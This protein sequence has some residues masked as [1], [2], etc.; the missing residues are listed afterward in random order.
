MT[1]QTSHNNRELCRVQ[2]DI[3]SFFKNSPLNGVDINLNRDSAS[4]REVDLL[5]EILRILVIL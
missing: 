1:S 2:K 5:R 4:I 3:V